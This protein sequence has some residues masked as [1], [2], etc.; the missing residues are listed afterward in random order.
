M[1]DLMWRNSATGEVYC[2]TMNGSDVVGDGYVGTVDT[3][4]D[5][6]GAGDY[7]GDGKADL[8]WRRT[9]IG[10]VWVWLMNDAL[11]SAEARVGVVADTQYEIGW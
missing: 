8:L 11:K 6:E 1:A 9:S 5:I 10:E 7:D 2:W 4:Y 3:A